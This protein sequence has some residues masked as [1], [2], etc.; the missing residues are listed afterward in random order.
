MKI[1]IIGD[2]HFGY[3]R[4][5][6]DSFSQGAESILSAYEKAEMII[7]AGDIFDTKIPTMETIGETVTIFE[8]LKNKDWEVKYSNDISKIP[9][10]AIHG[11]HERRTKGSLNPIQLLAKMNYLIDVDNNCSIFD[12]NEEKVC[13]QGM[14]GVPDEFAKNTLRALELK[15]K[16]GMFNILVLHQSIK[17]FMYI[18]EK[19][20]SLISLNDLPQGFDLYINGHI[21]DY[22]TGL[23]GK[24]IIPGSTVV[25][26]LKPNEQGDKGYVI[27]DTNTKTHEFIPIKTR[28]FKF[29]ELTF[30]EANITDI[31]NKCRKTIEEAIQQY[32]EK[33]IIKI[34]LKGNLKKGLE[35]KDLDLSFQKEYKDKCFL[36]ISNELNS[37]SLKQKIDKIREIREEKKSIKDFG[38]LIFG[39]KLKNAG[40]ELNNPGAVLDE[41]TDKPE[42]IIER[43]KSQ[44][45]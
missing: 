9:I 36:F 11:T 44:E 35:T 1:A 43:I 15:P 16:E 37:E 28:N 29:K 12:L 10:A 5:Q 20:S 21:H 3:K 25:T 7:L 32:K 26:Q 34:N 2:T 33:P 24:F 40:I 30:E 4:F 14:G 38:A 31:E 13:I 23:E 41:L 8:I 19:T 42:Q 22:K 18:G 45:D 27:Y 17:E 39:E 6:E